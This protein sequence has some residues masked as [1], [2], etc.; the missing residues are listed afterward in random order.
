MSTYK[1]FN[2]KIIS[3][4]IAASLLST[5]SAST[6]AAEEEMEVINVQARSYSDS[7]MKALSSK[8]MANGSVDTILAEDIADFPDQNLAEALQRIP[9]VAISREAGEGREITVRGLN[10]TFTRVQLNGMQAQSLAAGSGGVQTSRGFDFNV[11][12]SELF[13]RLDVHKTTSAQQEE[14]SLG[15]TVSLRTARPFDFKDEQVMA[16]NFQEAYNDLSEELSP[17]ASGLYSI[18]NSDMTLGALISASYSER[19]VKNVGSDTGRWTQDPINCDTCT[20]AESEEIENS[21]HPRFPRYSD[22]THDQ[23]R[24]GLTGSL[25]WVPTDSTQVSFDVLYAN[26]ESERREPFMQAIS[27]ARTGASGIQQSSISDYM[28]DSNDNI[29][30]ATI[31]D[32]DVRAENFKADWESEFHQ[33]SFNVDHYITDDFSVKLLVGQ[34]KSVLDNQEQTV[35]YEHFSDNDDRKQRNYADNSSAVTYDLT[36]MLDPKISYSYDTAN[37]NNWEVSEYRNRIFDAESDTSTARLDFEYILN[38]DIKLKAG[39]TQKSYGYEIAGVRGDSAFNSEDEADGTVDG[40]ACGIS[41]EVDAADGQE[42]TFGRQTFFM[43]NDAQFTRFSE[44]GCWDLQPRA[45]DTRSVEEDSLGIY[46]QADFI[47]DLGGSELRG[48]LGVRHVKTDLTSTGI[49]NGDTEVTVE[50]DYSD[51][52]PALNL[53]YSLTDDL[54]LRGSF[55]KVMSR[56]NLGTLNPG[57]SVSIFGTPAVSYG[58]PYIEPF[59]ADATDFSIEWYFDEGALLS[60]A[61]FKKDIESLP[62]SSRDNLPWNQVGLPDSLLGA[63][64]DD[65]KDETFEVRRTINGVGGELDGFEIQ[66]QQKLDFLPGPDWV[67]KFGVLANMT[68]VDSE[69]TYGSDRKGPLTGQSDES[70][71]FTLYWEDE[72]FSARVSMANRGE[73]FSNLGSSDPKNWRFIEDSSHV[74]M[75]ASYQINENIKVSIEGI[76]L[77]D[78]SANEWMDESAPRIISSQNTGRQVFFGISYRK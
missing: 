3:Q 76:N 54:L 22:K 58:N 71:N 40:M 30:S 57:G 67:Q 15:A 7:L 72:K 48:N 2:A 78:E 27:L 45:G 10:S 18:K 35:I 69:V 36:D 9:G 39:A 26:I 11:F 21:W 14:G 53:S 55:A 74:D 19:V 28:I 51:T 56:P 32:V 52:L 75:S 24:L 77:T 37:P 64:Y 20:T 25:Q 46:G 12:A 65:L 68:F 62:I 49:Q 42:V 1:K 5:A 4:V 73:Y 31:A 17:R 13:N 16:V 50:H 33:Y 66:Y 41:Y 38:D 70:S 47:F 43:S 29:I 59:R 8:K 34:S 23:N 60:L 61:Y 6:F 63:Q 44:S